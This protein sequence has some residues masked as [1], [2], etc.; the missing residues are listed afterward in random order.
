MLFFVVLLVIMVIAFFICFSPYHLQRL[1]TTYVE[2]MTLPYNS[3]LLS[4]MNVL[5][6]ISGFF[7]YMS[8][9]VNPLNSLWSRKFRAA[10]NGLFAPRKPVQARKIQFNVSLN[11]LNGYS[12]I[13]AGERP[14]RD[15]LMSI[16]HQ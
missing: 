1:L 13:S 10:Y 16:R 12:S 15:E 9:T 11:R 2:D 4:F 14:K 7:Y 5:Y 3:Q 6:A 8:T